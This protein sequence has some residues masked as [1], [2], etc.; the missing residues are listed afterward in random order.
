MDSPTSAEQREQRDSFS[1]Q[2]RTV[3]IGIRLLVNLTW[4]AYKE[5]LC[6]PP[7]P[8]WKSYSEMLGEITPPGSLEE[9][10]SRPLACLEFSERELGKV[11][12]LF[13]EHGRLDSELTLL[14]SE[15]QHQS[16]FLPNAHR[17]TLKRL[18][19]VWYELAPI[20]SPALPEDN[21]TPEDSSQSLPSINWEDLGPALRIAG[22]LLK[23]R[24]EFIA[25]ME[26]ELASLLQ[27]LHN[28]TWDELPTTDALEEYQ[29]WAARWDA[30]AARLN[31]V[32]A[33]QNLMVRG[34]LTEVPAG[35]VSHE[36][37]YPWLYAQAKRQQRR[38]Q[39]NA[40][41]DRA[42]EQVAKLSRSE[43]VTK[44]SRS[45]RLA[46]ALAHI[47]EHPEGGTLRG[48]ARV[49]KCAPTTLSRDKI[50]NRAVAHWGQGDRRDVPRGF[51]KDDDTLEA[52][53]R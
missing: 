42:G 25:A 39:G 24:K 9:V 11:C 52:E 16:G 33:A 53:A 21:P 4:R 46:R 13:P 34:I 48:L 1:I 27:R 51:R 38:L 18:Y 41:E 17:A 29:D 28:G 7:P 44:L 5:I 36:D 15:Q 6:F 26:Q 22:R 2:A 35:E 10:W 43:Q 23:P 20:L 19:A 8:A 14:R 12:R 31:D 3:C 49:L 45:E 30:A 37:L 50:I 47:A 40:N 32:C